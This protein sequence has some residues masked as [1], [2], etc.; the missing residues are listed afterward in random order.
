M[1]ARD[2]VVYENTQFS[3]M[4][5]RG[6]LA[7]T[8]ENGL[9]VL[10]Y[11]PNGRS[12]YFYQRSIRKKR[13][14]LH[15]TAG[16]LGGDLS[17]LTKTDYHV[18][19]PFVIARDGRIYRL[20]NTKYWSYHLGRAA[21]GGNKTCSSTSLG[22]ELSNIGPLD[23]SGNW[24]WNAYG[25]KYCRITETEYYDTGPEY[26]GYKNFAKFTDAQYSALNEL[27]TVLCVKHDILRTYLPKTRRFKEFSSPSQGR[28]FKGICSHVN[29]RKY[30]KTDIGPM[31]DWT[32][33]GA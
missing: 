24:M 22:I 26:R 8:H 18:S 10:D 15:F 30:G 5:A 6:E 31:F 32:K 27:L 7:A 2:L 4:T 21:I 14:V 23:K 1:L 25:S 19:V 33:I 12:D 29:Y 13:I 16:F 20:F 17:T 11:T 9:S 3:R 28:G